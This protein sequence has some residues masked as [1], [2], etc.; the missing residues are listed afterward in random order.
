MTSGGTFRRF[1]AFDR[2]VLT[3]IAAVAGLI[4]V[5]ILL[6]D[7]V[8]VQV[9]RVTPLG[10]ARSTSP[11]RVTFSENM[12]RET[13]ESRFRVEPPLDGDF[14]WNGATLTFRPT[15]VL[16]PGAAY[17]VELEPG[18]QS[19]S[20]RALLSTIRFSFSVR[21]PRVAYLYP[22]DDVPQNIWVVDP[23]NPD[24]PAQITDSPTG[25]Y[26]F[27]VSPD[28]TQIAF[29]ERNTNGTNDIKLIDLETGALRQL[30]NCQDSSCT[31]PVWRPDGRLIAYERVDFNTDLNLNR[32]PTRIWLL[33]P[34]ADPATTRPLFEESQ[35]LG[36]NPQWSADGNRIALFD[37]SSVAILI[38]DFTTGEIFAVP[39]R[40]GTSGALSP[41]GTRLIFSEVPAVT[42]G[43]AVRQYLR[44]IDIADQSSAAISSP[45]DPLEDDQAR[46]NPDGQRVAITRRYQD[47]RY[48]RGYQLY[49]LDVDAPEAARPLIDDPAYADG[50]FQW[51]PTGTQIVA[52][53]IRLLDEQGQPD[54][55][56]RPEIWTVNT[57]T[58][59]RLRVALNSYLPQWVP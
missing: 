20:G 34:I 22:A 2:V 30:T 35:I 33:D 19:E 58:G 17:Q 46:W 24:A 4:V 51:D 16:I 56:A 13:V 47:E 52:Q 6:G 23:A 49:V 55:L 3:V 25:I 59:A 32:S 50:V 18:A 11:I 27:A 1:S 7:R 5:T 31:T 36:Y 21:T 9:S 44:L 45:G 48:T 42:E 54:N 40:S 39:S 43:E 14:S 15:E 28:G 57:E 53:R 8:G 41:D 10:E 29:A 37:N 26:D 12:Q 38:Y